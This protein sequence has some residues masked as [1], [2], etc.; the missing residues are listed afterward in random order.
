MKSLFRLINLNKRQKFVF[1]VLAL[2]AG[3]FMSEHFTGIRLLVASLSLAIATVLKPYLA[4]LFLLIFFRYDK[5]KSL[6]VNFKYATV[7]G[8]SL[9]LI[10]APFT[11][12]NYI[13]FEKIQPF[14]DYDGGGTGFSGTF[15]S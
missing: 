4:P 11:I 13:R 6:P 7:F 14:S 5:S 3:V 15:L 9:L 8:I 10:I 2:S 12:R 1:A